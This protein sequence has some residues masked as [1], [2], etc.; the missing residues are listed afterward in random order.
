MHDLPARPART[1]RARIL[2][3][4]AA[5][6]AAAAALAA[7][8]SG[9]RPRSAPARAQPAGSVKITNRSDW[10]IH[11]LYLSPTSTDDW[12]PDQLQDAVLG[13]GESFTLT[14]VPCDSYDVKLV[15]EAGDECVVVDVAI[16]GAGEGWVIRNADLLACQEG[17]PEEATAQARCPAESE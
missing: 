3:R 8:A 2:T 11:H 4:R 16:C 15:D 9:V 12:G 14:G 10:E 17:Q 13:T 7:V 6:T 1:T 5:L